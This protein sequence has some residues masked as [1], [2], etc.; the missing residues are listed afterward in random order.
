MQKIKRFSE[1]LQEGNAFSVALKKA[2]ENGDKEFEF[3]GKKYKVKNVNESQ[4]KTGDKFKHPIYKEL[5]GTIEKGPDTFSAIESAG[6]DMPSDEDIADTGIKTAELNKKVWYG[7][8]THT[9]SSIGIHTN[10]IIKETF[11]FKSSENFIEFLE[12]IEKMSESDIRDIMSEQYIDTPGFY[13]EEKDIHESILSF[14]MENMGHEEFNKLYDW[15]ILNVQTIENINE[16]KKVSIKRKYTDSHPS[17]NVQN[18]APVREKVLSFIGEKGTVDH[19]QILEFLR[20]MNE[21]HSKKTSMR[22]VKRNSKYIKEYE[23]KGTKN[24]KLTELGKRVLRNINVSE[25][26]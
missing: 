9:G 24:Y 6:F 26:K 21:Q 12:E 20:G 19:K 14:M 11:S 10:E 7:V 13:Y 3:E 17:I 25:N 23:S 15:W 22:W 5:K 16:A 2:R 18:Y 8:K 1:V 4:L